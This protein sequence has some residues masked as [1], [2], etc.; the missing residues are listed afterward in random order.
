MAV[1]P[2]QFL[3]LVFRFA[4]AFVYLYLFVYFYK[5]YK[6]SKEQGLANKYF[7]GFAFLFGILVVFHILYGSYE[8]Y[9][10]ILEPTIDLK[11]R[12]PWY[13]E[14]TNQVGSLSI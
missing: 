14:N 3:A 9:V 8:F 5:S 1:A 13:D 7:Y 2:E 6:K 10:N 4:M 12:F 11:Q